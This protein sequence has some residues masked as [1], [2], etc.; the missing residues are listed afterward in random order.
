M[1]PCLFVQ[2]MTIIRCLHLIRVCCI[3]GAW[4]PSRTGW[5]SITKKG[6]GSDRIRKRYR[7]DRNGEA[8]YVTTSSVQHGF[9]A[10]KHES[11]SKTSVWKV[12]EQPQS[13]TSSAT[14]RSNQLYHIV[15]LVL[16]TFKLLAARPSRPL[17]A[18]PIWHRAR[19]FLLRALRLAASANTSNALFRKVCV[20]V[21]RAAPFRFEGRP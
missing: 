17:S 18:L 9:W 6:G 13:S 15:V 7:T 8:F 21:S 12:K 5:A 20:S 19:Y 10:P 1:I 11:I 4:R 14:K 3:Y 2:C 16:N